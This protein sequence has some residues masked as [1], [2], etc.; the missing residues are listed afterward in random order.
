MRFY[1]GCSGWLYSHWRGIFYPSQEPTA[2]NWFAYYANVFGTVELNAPFYR[3]PKPATV[4]RWKRDAP[5]NFV[6]SVKVNQRITHEKR[7]VRTKALVKSYYDIAPVLGEKLGCFL[8]QFPPS[9]SYSVSRLKSIVGQLDP[10]Y[11]NVV[12]F[13]HR[14]WWRDTVYRTLAERGI[15]FCA[16]SAPR[17]PEAVPTGQ[18]VLYLR[19]SGR[20]RWYRH[21]YSAEELRT[22]LERV[23]AS[24]AEEAW[25]YFNNDREGFAVKNALMLRRLLR[26]LGADAMPLPTP[27]KA[28]SLEIGAPAR[29]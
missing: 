11:R 15:T 17:L 9:H 7:L 10:T 25:I 18:R 16:V 27:R 26:T 20:T 5:P 24:G 2:R 4:R 21:D 28:S 23:R 6:Y 3:W 19:L 14:S 8:F 29:T 22:W 1:V 13:R 12:E